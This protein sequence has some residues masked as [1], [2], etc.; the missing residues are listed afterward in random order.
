[1]YVQISNALLLP[2]HFGEMLCFNNGL[3]HIKSPFLA[4]YSTMP[5]LQEPCRNL[6]LTLQCVGRV[7]KKGQRK[8]AAFFRLAFGHYFSMHL[9]CELISDRQSEP[10]A[11]RGM[12]VVALIQTLKNMLQMFRFDA[13]AIIR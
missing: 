12:I 13:D 1:M 3:I 2:I 6:A 5:A 8:S 7:P 11:L 10:A 4:A 9:F